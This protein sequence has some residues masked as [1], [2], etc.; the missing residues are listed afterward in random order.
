MYI[1]INIYVDVAFNVAVVFDLNS[2]GTSIAGVEAH[3]LQS[4]EIHSEQSSGS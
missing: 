2:P 4:R 3:D 1:I